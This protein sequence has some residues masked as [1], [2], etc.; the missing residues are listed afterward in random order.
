MSTL[1]II[2]V[3]AAVILILGAIVY[4]LCKRLKALNAELK[5]AKAEI[6][7]QRDNLSYLVKHSEEIAKIRKEEKSVDKAIEEAESNEELFNIINGLISGN[8]DRVCK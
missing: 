7:K 3:V 5:D 8:N 2:L 4:V 6:Q 1:T